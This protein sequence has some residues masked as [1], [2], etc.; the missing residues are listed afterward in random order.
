MVCVINSTSIPKGTND[1][2]EAAG[3]SAA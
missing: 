1:R 3:V 2:R